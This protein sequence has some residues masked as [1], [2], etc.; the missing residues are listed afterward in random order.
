M[1][2]TA[3]T[4]K[5]K[6]NSALKHARVWL[7]KQTNRRKKASKTQL[8]NIFQTAL[9]LSTGA[10]QDLKFLLYS[11]LM[12]KEYLFIALLYWLKKT[13]IYFHNKNKNFF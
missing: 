9:L 4:D 13:F 6:Q 5:R 12:E 10:G 3:K 1:L 7:D 11:T 2:K 8:I